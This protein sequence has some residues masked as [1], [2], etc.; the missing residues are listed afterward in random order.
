VAFSYPL[1]VHPGRNSALGLWRGCDAD[2]DSWLRYNK[3][4]YIIVT[5]SYLGLSLGV[6]LLVSDLGVIFSFVGATSAT[7]IS[8][9][10][11]GAAYYKM[12]VEENKSM[13]WRLYGAIFVFFLGCLI[14]PVCTTFIFL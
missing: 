7:M 14:T 13:D 9:I 12:H 5:A 2:D 8:L 10:L 3:F 1:L 4:R 11:P 6:A